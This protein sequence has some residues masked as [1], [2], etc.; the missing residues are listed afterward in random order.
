[1]NYPRPPRLFLEASETYDVVESE[2]LIHGGDGKAYKP[3]DYLTAFTQF[4]NENADEIEAI[5]ILLARPSG[6]N[7]GALGEL[8]A[9]L[10]QTPVSFTEDNLQRAH[11]VRYHKALAD[12]VSM[13]KHA[14]K[15]EEPLLT[16]EE[17]VTR[18]IAT[19]TADKDYTEEQRQW[20]DRIKEHLVKN[21]SIEQAHFD[22]IPILSR[23]GGW[24]KANRVF[25]SDL[26]VLL[27]RLNEAVAV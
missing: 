8:R 1:M 2:W 5:Q 24:G 17:R 15:S 4:V 7:T 21:L 20:L 11:Q 18:A 23:A 3:E 19:V 12:I 10:R 6:W 22:V 14:A 27:T 13:V 25:N 9:K 16:A 26:G